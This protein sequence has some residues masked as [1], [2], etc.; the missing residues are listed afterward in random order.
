MAAFYRLQALTRARHQLPPQPVKWF[1]SLMACFGDR[2]TIHTISHRGRAIA[3]MVTLRH[4]STLT[5]KYGASEAESHHL[6]GVVLLMWKVIQ[7]AKAWGCSVLDLGRSDL[8]STGLIEFKEHWG[9]TRIPMS[10]LRSPKPFPQDSRAAEQL[11]LAR[12]IFV[13]TPQRIVGLA[14]SLL[15]KHVG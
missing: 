1:R 15:Y 2:L 3:S 7:R 4:G 8:D 12:K 14:G 9:A 5:Y 11:A 10:Y 13:H 6:G